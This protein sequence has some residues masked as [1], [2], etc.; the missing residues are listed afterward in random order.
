MSA[1]LILMFVYEIYTATDIILF[2]GKKAMAMTLGP[3]V[4]TFN[5]YPM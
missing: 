5:V 4:E 1:R 2:Q 3:D